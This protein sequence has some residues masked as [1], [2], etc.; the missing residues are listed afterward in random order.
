MKNRREWYEE[1]HPKAAKAQRIGLIVLLIFVLMIVIGGIVLLL[2]TLK[3]DNAKPVGNVEAKPYVIQESELSR[4]EESQA[5]SE[6][7]EES[8]ETTQTAGSSVEESSVTV[9]LEVSSEVQSQEPSSEQVVIPPLPERSYYLIVVDAGH[10]GKDVGANNDLLGY[11]VNEKDI[12]LAVALYLKSYLEE[13]SDVQVIMTRDTD[14]FI[15]LS[16]R[17]AVA[18]TEQANLFVSV[19]CNTYEKDQ[20]VKGLECYYHENDKKRSG[21]MA[22]TMITSLKNSGLDTKIRGTRVADYKVLREAY[23]PAVL[24]EMGFMTNPDELAKLASEDYQKQLAKAI[25]DAVYAA[26]KK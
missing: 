6:S 20:K 11:T 10:G 26:V 24:F 7:S 25:A 15:E 18:N 8:L 17:P 4:P 14:R 22:E 2:H 23:Y 5:S 19:H 16:D 3:S 12:D 21:I 1:N 13:K 9:S